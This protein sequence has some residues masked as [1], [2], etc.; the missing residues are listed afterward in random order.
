MHTIILV[1]LMAL[2]MYILNRVAWTQYH[3]PVFVVMLAIEL[4]TV[5]AISYYLFKRKKAIVIS[6]ITFITGSGLFLIVSAL[7]MVFFVSGITVIAGTMYYLFDKVTQLLEPPKQFYTTVIS[8]FIA[9]I[10][11]YGICMI[12]ARLIT[13]SSMVL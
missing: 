1:N 13:V 6:Y 11:L 4:L 2:T 3:I 10:V 7:P 5:G 8:F 9:S 12:A